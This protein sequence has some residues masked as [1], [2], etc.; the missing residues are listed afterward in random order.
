[1]DKRLFRSFISL[2]LALSLSASLLQSAAIAQ[3]KI[4]GGSAGG[5]KAANSYAAALQTIEDKLDARRKELGIPGVSLVIVKDGQV[6]YSKG[7][8]YKDFEK[9]VPVTADTQFAIGSAT[10]AFTALT[11]LMAQDEGKLSLD[12]SP[13]KYLPYFHMYD[14]ETD[15]NITIRDLLSHSSGLNRTDL[16]M[17]TGKLSRAELIEVAAQAKPN[18]KLREKFQYQKLSPSCC[19]SLC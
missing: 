10:K 19:F 16:A 4:S 13:K 6:I 18:A 2:L 7:L 9:K 14:P 3:A 11:V 8:G 1:M 5:T 15:R 17:I 12:D